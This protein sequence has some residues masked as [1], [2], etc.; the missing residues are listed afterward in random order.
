MRSLGK[1]LSERKARKFREKLPQLFSD[2]PEPKLESCDVCTR[3]DVPVGTYGPYGEGSTDEEPIN[4]CETCRM[5]DRASRK[6]VGNEYLASAGDDLR[7][8]EAGYGLSGNPRNAL[9]ALNGVRD[10]A[11]LHG[12]VPLPAARYTMWDEERKDQIMDFNKLSQ[13]A[14]GSPR[15]AVLRMDVDNLGEIFRRGLPENMRTFDRYASLSRSFTTFFKMV[16][17]LICAGGYE[18]SLWLFGEEHER[19]ATVVYSGGDDLFIVGAWSDVLELAV[20]VRRAFREFVCGNPSVTISAGI[21]IH[22]AGEPL[23]LM[24]EQ[25]GTAE[26]MAKKNEQDERKKDSAVL[27]YRGPETGKPEQDPASGKPEHRVPQALFWDEIEEVV[28]LLKRI[29]AFRGPDGE[30]PFPRGF[31]RLLIEVAEV[32]EREGHL[33]LPRLAYAL[34]RMEEGGKLRDDEGW[35]VLKRELLKIETVKK[36]LRPAAY[37]LDLAEREKGE[38]DG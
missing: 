22:K 13:K 2:Q 4:L 18:N 29:D 21:S 5:L 14:A 37:W 34:V 25:A 10:E 16:V 26:G 31:T 36:Y 32:Y 38:L 3:D 9:Y 27:F 19:A 20:D 30:L 6:L 35:Q 28:R 24:A 7:I 15:L 8:G 33:S 17:P 11:C 1:D 12:A 23:Y